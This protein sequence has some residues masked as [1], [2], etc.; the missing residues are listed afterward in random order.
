MVLKE[1]SFNPAAKEM[2]KMFLMLA[3]K[4]RGIL[5]SENQEVII[6]FRIRAARP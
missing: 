3:V 5:I 1:L 2:F 6:R 4:N